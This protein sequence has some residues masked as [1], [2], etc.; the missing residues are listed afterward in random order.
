MSDRPLEGRFWFWLFVPVLVRGA[1]NVTPTYRQAAR[2][3]TEQPLFGCVELGIVEHTLAVHRAQLLELGDQ[4]VFTSAG[5][6]SRGR[7]RR[8]LLLLVRLRFGLLVSGLL[9]AGHSPGD[10][11]GR[12]GDDGGA[13]SHAHEPW[14][15]SA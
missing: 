8:V 13:G 10:S 5:R 3:R 4:V 7:R 15:G 2:S 6:S 12:A 14:S 1:G 11:G 9:T